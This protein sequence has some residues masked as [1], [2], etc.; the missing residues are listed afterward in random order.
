M[1]LPPLARLEVANE[2]ANPFGDTGGDRFL[3]LRIAQTPALAR[4]RDE[5]NLHQDCWNVDPHQHVKRGLLNPAITGECGPDK[6]LVDCVGQP[7]RIRVS[8]RPSEVGEDLL[9]GIA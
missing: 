7:R 8:F 1:S 5:S 9:K 4:V 2:V 3:V 6:R